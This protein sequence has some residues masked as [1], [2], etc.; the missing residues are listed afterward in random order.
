MNYPVWDP[1]FAHGVLIAAV[2]ILHVYISHF[3]IGGGLFL[4]VTETLARRRND[5]GLLDYLHLH[6]RFFILLT[7]VFGAITGVGIWFTIGLINP[8]G[9][10]NLIHAFVWGWAIEWV[11]FLVEII[12]ALIYYY[13]WKTMR[14]RDHLIVGWIYFAAAWLSLA[15]INGILSFQLTP[16]KWIQTHGF[17]DGILNP[18]YFSSLVGRS[19]FA[20]ALAG[21]F[22]LWTATRLQWGPL[23][24]WLTRYAGL[25]AAVGLAGAFLSAI[26]WWDGLPA[27]VRQL[28]AGNMPI[29]MEAFKVAVWTIRGLVLLVVVLAIVFPR[30]IN[31]A[32]SA[33]ILLFGLVVIGSGEWLRE[34]IRKPWVIQ[35]YLYSNGLRADEVKTIRSAG[36]VASDPW[37]DTSKAGNPLGM[38]EEIFRAACK[39]CH[40]RNGYNGL[41]ARVRGWDEEFTAGFIQRLEYSLRPMPPW[42]GTQQEAHELAQYLLS[43]PKAK[44]SETRE[45]DGREVY[46]KRCSSCHTLYEERSLAERLEGSNAQDIDEFLQDME[47]DEMPAFTAG[48]AQRHALARYLEKAVGEGAPKDQTQAEGSAR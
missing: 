20:I 40:S 18:S 3:A 15:V 19:A 47:S 48:E 13:G 5:A 45:L 10:D 9:T 44:A 31:P 30:G 21:L 7:L 26:W 8:A 12:S 11:F 29:A 38:G 43:L 39:N 6:S 33:L 46:Q 28:A 14:A 25:W 4:V 27:A 24:R 22:C 23:R 41:A 17:W 34:A 32:T 35:N 42:V 37:I 36:I 1:G 2:A 16:G